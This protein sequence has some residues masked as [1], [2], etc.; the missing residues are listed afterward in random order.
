MPGFQTQFEP[1]ISTR[2]VVCQEIQHRIRH[3]VRAGAN[4]QANDV[5]TSQ[6]FVVEAPQPLYA[7]IGIGVSLEIG[8]E[9]LRPIALVQKAFALFQL[10]GHGQPPISRTEAGVVTVNTA[11]D[12]HS[13]ISVGTSK[14]SVKRNFMHTATKGAAQMIRKTHI[15]LA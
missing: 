15:T 14:T 1:Q 13:A 4:G 3:T 9:F 6:R 10:R 2:G 7:T 8:N 11:S 12:S 5:L